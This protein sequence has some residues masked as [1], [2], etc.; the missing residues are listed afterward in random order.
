ML[1]TV[2]ILA[3]L[4]ATIKSYPSYSL[5]DIDP[6]VVNGTDA[7]ISEFPWMV[8]VLAQ[9]S[10]TFGCGGSI[11]SHRWVMTAAH[12]SGSFVRYGTDYAEFGVTIQIVRFIR[13]E[14]F[15]LLTLVNDIA[16]CE[17]ESDILFSHNAQPV[18]LPLDF[19]EVPG[20]WLTSA[21]VLGFG[22]NATGGLY[23]KHLQRVQ[24]L[25]V[26]NEECSEAYRISPVYD[27]M[28]CAS[29][30]G[31]GQGTCEGDSGGPLTLTD[32]TQVG[33]VSWSKKPTCAVPD[34]PNVFTKVSHF[35]HWIRRVTGLNLA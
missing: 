1:K 6:F 20:N 7:K 14:D 4:V 5:Q 12:C 18:R 27:S 22:L 21:I 32:G 24:L 26:E 3:T 13:H 10:S 29:V 31:G 17:L 25:V 16:V 35:K 34:F 11:L 23:Q 9:E 28:I 33:I 2:L 19:Y 30:V 15:F 8:S